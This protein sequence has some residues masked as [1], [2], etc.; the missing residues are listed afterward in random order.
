MPNHH[1]AWCRVLRQRLLLQLSIL[2]TYVIS[3][4]AQLANQSLPILYHTSAL[5][6]QAWVLELMTG[7]PNHIGCEL[8]VS[9]EIFDNLIK[10]LQ[11]IGYT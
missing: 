8:S 6:G 10:H 11:E 5:S 1:E 3:I 2:L 9:L 7:H 4:M